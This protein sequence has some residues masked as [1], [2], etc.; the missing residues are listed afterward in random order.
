MRCIKKKKT[1]VLCHPKAITH[2]L[3]TKSRQMSR[4]YKIFVLILESMLIYLMCILRKQ[5]FKNVAVKK[6]VSLSFR[7]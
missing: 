1:Y 4:K 6:Y 5:R 3:A 2:V 7:K